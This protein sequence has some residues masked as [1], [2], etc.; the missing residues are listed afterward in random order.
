MDSLT[1]VI[2]LIVL[3]LCSAFF[4]MT[5][6]AFSYCD[7][8]KM[9]IS[10]DEGKNSSKLVIKCLNQFDKYII[11]NLIG[12]NIVNILIS[13]MSTMLFVSLFQD[14]LQIENYT[15]IGSLVSIIVSTLIVFFVGEIIPKHIGKAFPNKICQIVIYPLLVLD[16]LL[17]PITLIFRGLVWLLKKIFKTKEDEPLL[18]E[19]D[20]KHIVGSIEKEGLIKEEEKEIIQSAV[21]FDDMKVKQVMCPRE[22]ICA[23]NINETLSKEDLIDYI[24]DSPFTRIPVYKDS[25]DHIIGILHTQKLLKALM[26]KENYDIEKLLVEP[27]FV[28]PNVHLDTIFEDMKKQKTHMAIVCDKEGNTLGIVTMEDLLEELV[29]DIDE[30]NEGGDYHE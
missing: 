30:S 20:L 5:E 18:D 19:E 28:R 4:S 24:V 25:I 16:I 14:T 23:L 11:T 22:N 6:N 27:I 13:V 2:L 1:R 15:E 7:Q 9:K 21:D 26:T 12:N 8:F 17:T 29:G 10:S 3:L